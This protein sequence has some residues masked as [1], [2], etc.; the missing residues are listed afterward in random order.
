MVV[1]SELTLPMPY[2]ECRALSLVYP[3]E[4]AAVWYALQQQHGDPR[5]V[6][7]GMQLTDGRWM[8]SGSVLSEIHAGG[9]LGWVADC[10]SPELM[11]SIEVV[12]LAEA[13][14]M[15]PETVEDA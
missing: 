7:V 14:A 1:L 5:H 12:P 15:L 10:L 13:V 9:I 6:G 2:E 8:M 11:A 4:V 3:H